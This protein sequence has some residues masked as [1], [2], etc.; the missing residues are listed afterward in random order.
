MGPFSRAFSI[1]SALPLCLSLACR[2]K[3]GAGQSEEAAAAAQR[4]ELTMQHLKIQ[5]YSSTGKDWEIVSPQAQG[6]TAKNKLEASDIQ[7][8]LFQS[9]VKSTDIR[10]DR[11]ILNTENPSATP[12]PASSPSTLAHRPLGP[13]DMY[14]DGHVVVVSSD[15]TKLI[16]DW[17]RF[18]KASGLIESTA[19]VHVVRADSETR[20]FGIE[21]T[22]N[23]SSVK[24]FNETLTLKGRPSKK[25]RK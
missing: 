14:L 9:G 13:G 15:G 2:S 24:I 8:A 22:S 20:G 3:P 25:K 19:P 17:L 6:F 11:G 12:T 16:T 7:V 21:A 5:S 4:P 10:A 23:L 18:S 1:L